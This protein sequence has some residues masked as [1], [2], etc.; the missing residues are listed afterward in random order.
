MDKKQ[1]VTDKV[2]KLL[3]Q[4][5]DV[6][7]TPEES[8]FQAKAFEL[9]AKYGLDMAQVDAKRANLDISDMPDAIQWAANLTGTYQSAQLLLLN[10][11]ARALHCRC[12]CTRTNSSYVV[13]VFGM[14]RHI[15]RVKFLW[16][17]LQPQMMRQVKLAHP[18]YY[19]GGV[20]SYRRA[21]I[22]GFANTIGQ[23]VREQEDKAVTAAG[24]LVLYK[25]DSQRAEAALQK[26]FPEARDK[27]QSNYNRSGWE[28]GAAAGRS[29]QFNRAIA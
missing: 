21:W 6:A 18:G 11:I 20:K 14:E 4:A 1:K 28:A 8:V 16:G 3:R 13:N 23:R 7:G 22:A 29:A 9:L 24:A 17:I 19:G 2:A 10:G 26:A 5:E 27:R 25:G 12:V 15:E